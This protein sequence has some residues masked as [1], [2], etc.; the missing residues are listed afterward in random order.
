MGLASRIEEST[1]T[2]SITQQDLDEVRGAI[3]E[4]TRALNGLKTWVAEAIRD[5]L[6]SQ[7][8]TSQQ[9]ATSPDRI[10]SVESRLSEIE[11]TLSEFVSALDGKRL[12]SAQQKLSES[13]ASLAKTGAYQSERMAKAAAEAETVVTG[14]RK[15]ILQ[16]QKAAVEAIKQTAGE[17]AGVVTAKL[18]ESNQTAKRVIRAADRLNSKQLWTG[19]GVLGLAVIPVATVCSFVMLFVL[20]A[21]KVGAWV[22]DLAG[23]AEHWWST[24]LVGLM[25]LAAVVG[26]GW[27]VLAVAA[28][29][30]EKLSDAIRRFR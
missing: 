3:N 22:F 30:D 2:P 18:D 27:I 13:A 15:V 6:S 17:S 11:Q 1:S 29:L 24:G 7:R 19:V 16:T 23:K 5:G 28:W 25:T 26:L 20:G 4:Q 14:A 10:A 9:P 21:W 12:E 8:Q